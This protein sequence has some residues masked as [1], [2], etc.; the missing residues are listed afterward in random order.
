MNPLEAK[1]SGGKLLRHSAQRGGVFLGKASCNKKRK[2]DILLG[3]WNIRSLYRAGSLRA[4]ARY[5][6]D[7]VG[8]QEVRRDRGRERCTQGVGGETRGKETIGETK[9]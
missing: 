6:L 3:T 2:R 8:V 5:K 7:V 9:A 4:A 1:E